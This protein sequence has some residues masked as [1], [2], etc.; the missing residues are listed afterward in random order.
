MTRLNTDRFF[1]LFLFSLNVKSTGLKVFLS[2][3]P[4]FLSPGGDLYLI[5]CQLQTN[6]R[7]DFQIQNLIKMTVTGV[8]W[9][10]KQLMPKIISV[11][12][13]NYLKHASSFIE[14]T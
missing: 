8:N 1:F 9:Q 5:K 6:F 3:V 13:P 7:V 10:N 12:L 2:L 4:L 11:C 14:V